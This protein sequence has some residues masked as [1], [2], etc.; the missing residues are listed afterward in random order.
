MRSSAI[1]LLA[2]MHSTAWAEVDARRSIA[3]DAVVTVA[4]RP[5]G[6]SGALR[7]IGSGWEAAV[8]R[9]LHLPGAVNP[10]EP[11]V[12]SA[13]G[14]D[15]AMMAWA[16]VRP[17]QSGVHVRIALPLENA[18]IAEALV[19]TAGVAMGATLARGSASSSWVGKLRDGS[20]LVVRLDGAVLVADVVFPADEAPAAAKLQKLIPLR[21]PRGFTLDHGAAKRIGPA[22]AIAV[23]TDLPALVQLGLLQGERNVREALRNVASELRAKLAKAG[24]D[25]LNGCRAALRTLPASFED[26]LISVAITGPDELSAEVTLGGKKAGLDALRVRDVRATRGLAEALG[27][28]DLVGAVTEPILAR[29][30]APAS[31][32]VVISND[33]LN[34]CGWSKVPL[35]LRSWPT[36]LASRVAPPPIAPGLRAAAPVRGSTTDLVHFLAGVRGAAFAL[37]LAE[38][39]SPST[40]MRQLVALAEAD[41]AGRGDL[42]RALLGNFGAVTPL[43]L[44]ARQVTAYGLPSSPWSQGE[45]PIIAVDVLPTAPSATLVGFGQRDLVRQALDRIGPASAAPRAAGSVAT[46]GIGERGLAR[47]LRDLGG[48]RELA[49]SM[50]DGVKRVDA[51]VVIEPAWLRVDLSFGLRPSPT[52]AP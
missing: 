4:V 23:W 40:M 46:F 22:H 51:E 19:Q 13:L 25:E 49:R 38:K 28:A 20:P 17:L 3:A 39:D 16:S 6:V 27:E 45:G 7:R 5:I 29:L 36:L 37:Q 33:T 47:A 43:K 26:L 14:V 8:R 35:V 44:A 24:N 34:A 41:P 1:F 31:S 12:V 10:F 42:D 11:E 2:V 30:L 50:V 52:P 9:F 32:S 15:P 18:R 48:P 21:P